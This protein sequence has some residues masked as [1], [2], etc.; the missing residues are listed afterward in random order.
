VTEVVVN[1]LGTPAP[2]GSN[3]AMVRGGRAVFVPGGSKVNQVALKGWDVAVREA[4]LE[5][6]GPC[7]S[8]TFVD[9]PLAVAITFR[10]AR[11]GGHWRKQGG[12]SAS[13]PLFPSKKPD[14]DKLARS[15]IDSLSGLVFDDDAR[16]VELVVRKRYAEPGREGA[17]IRVWEHK[18]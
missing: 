8:P 17:E 3:R 10:L 7:L 15:T 11:P 1:V 5:Q 2:K 12:L 16:I 13:A 14:V 9:R 4:A 18:A 6:L